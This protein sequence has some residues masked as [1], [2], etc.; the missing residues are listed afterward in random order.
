MPSDIRILT[1]ILETIS[2]MIMPLVK[3]AA[4]GFVIQK[5]M[6]GIYWERAPMDRRERKQN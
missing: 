4:A 6:Q 1:E 3:S 2:D 5:Q